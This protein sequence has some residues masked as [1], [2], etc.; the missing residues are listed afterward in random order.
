MSIFNFGK[1]SKSGGLMDGVATIH[2]HPYQGGTK[3]CR[4]KSRH[5]FPASLVCGG[6]D[7]VFQ[8]NVSIL[9][10]ARWSSLVTVP[11]TR[12][13][14]ISTLCRFYVHTPPETKYTALASRSSTVQLLKC[15]DRWHHYLRSVA[16]VGISFEMTHV[17]NSFPCL[18]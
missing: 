8:R 2:G 16:N 1:R 13:A 5:H 17:I 10:N 18:H 14:T 4:A 7:G 11:E 15:R 3:R 6:S 9:M 12:T